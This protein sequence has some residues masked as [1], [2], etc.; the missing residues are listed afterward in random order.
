MV[1]INTHYKNVNGVNRL[2]AVVTKQLAQLGFKNQ[3]Y[4]QAEVGNI[5]FYTNNPDGQYDYLIIGN[6]DNA[7]SI[8]QQKYFTKNDQRYLGSGTWENKGGLVTMIYALKSLKYSRLLKKAKIGILLTTDD[9]QHGIYSKDI[10]KLK[11]ES[12]KTV[13][14]LH[15]AFLD[16]GLVTSRSG[17]AYYSLNFAL[18]SQVNNFDV[19]TAAS[20]FSKI[21]SDWTKLSSTEAGIIVSPQKIKFNSNISEPFVHGEVGLSVRYNNS[22]DFQLLDR[23]IRKA[24]PYNKYK[25]TLDFHFEGGMRR[26][27]MKMSSSDQE[28][29]DQVKTL[30]K[31]LD[32][33][34]CEEHRWSSA[35]ICLADQVKRRIDGFGPNGIKKTDGYEY[36]LKHTINEKALLLAMLLGNID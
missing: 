21:I 19:A 6:L 33:K 15:G 4:N 24:I 29:V 34:I 35:D 27:P 7:T 23:N 5:H 11:S 9:S 10:I 20:V 8:G 30:S 26:P 3:T 14:G 1:N 2:G 17:S 36:I 16:G 13:L 31:R 32:I 22:S 18:K 28:L 25:D 12:A